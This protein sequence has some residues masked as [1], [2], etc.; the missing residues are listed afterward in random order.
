VGV[1]CEG[2]AYELYTLTHRLRCHDQSWPHSVHQLIEGHEIGSGPRERE[3]EVERELRERN[4][5]FCACYAL[6]AEVDQK[7]ADLVAGRLR[8]YRS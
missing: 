1:I 4:L 7:I 6:T 2:V 3:K 5:N 8:G